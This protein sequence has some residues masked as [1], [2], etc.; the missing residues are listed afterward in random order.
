M[1]GESCAWHIDGVPFGVRIL[2]CIGLVSTSTA[3]AGDLFRIEYNNPGLTVDLGVGLWAW[4]L[5]MDYDG[6]GD[7][8]LIVSSGGVPYEGVYFFENDSAPDAAASMPIFRPGVRIG[9]YRSNV[10]ISYTAD[11]A[12]VVMTPGESHPEFFEYALEK[13][14]ELAFDSADVHAA[15]G[16]V[17]AKQWKQVDWEADGDPDIVI[18][19]GDWTQYGWDDAYDA[20]GNWTNGPLHGY[21]Y[22]ALNDGHGN[23]SEAK[24]VMAGGRPV[25][26]YGMPSPSF[27]DFDGDNDL[28]LICGEFLD[29]FTYFENTG[30]RREPR[31]AAGRRLLS[32]GRPVAMDLQMI[33][34]TAI[35]W[36]RDGD[37]DLVVGDE[38][39][40]VAFV[41]NLGRIDRGMPQFA[42]PKYFQQR[43]EFVKFG[44]LVTPVG[45]DWD[46]DGDEDILAGNSAG[47]IG[48]IENLDGG[49]PPKFAAPV[50]LTAGGKT[51][52]IQAGE[53]GSIQGPCEAKWGYTTISVADWDGD[54]LP[55]IVAN[56]IWGRIVWYRNAGSRTRPLLEPARPVAVDWGGE[57]DKPDWNWW[58]P[59]DKELVSQWRT[60]PVAAD[61]NGDGLQDIAMLDHEGYLA[62]FRRARQNGRLV[63][64][65]GERIFF[66]DSA[67][68][69]DRRHEIVNAVRGPLRLNAD[70]AGKS[71]RRKID[72]TDWD[73][74]GRI[75]ILVNSVSVD[76]MRNAGEQDGRSFFQQKGALTSRK[77][78][79]HTTSPTTVDWDGDGARDLLIGAEDGFLYWMANPAAP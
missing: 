67:S 68:G 77:L 39:G 43:A 47:Y 23:Y 61:W 17:R 71:G 42:Q 75:D 44:A 14:L 18:G 37:M 63:L 8:D 69:F 62:W 9:E 2:I 20:A 73:G 72:L 79:G 41:E 55:D 1:P 45:F 46:G 70:R 64:L 4:P 12:P 52:R 22:L 49:S 76:W 24:K 50:R 58:I 5:P 66:G 10:Q 78:A 26:V 36:D 54:S 34:P 38:D 16:R 48:F 13:P 35:D 28:D 59:G 65:P 25:D 56:S 33:T 40:R 29:G 53:N 6:D 51:I 3:G 57:S 74:D 27:A 21:V 60:R 7:T 31:Y 11:G 30:T 15:Q 32:D 19:I